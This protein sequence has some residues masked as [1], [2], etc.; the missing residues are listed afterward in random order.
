A[1]KSMGQHCEDMAREWKSGRRE[2][3]ELALASHK[4]TVAA[5]DAG[6]FDDLITPVDGVSRDAFP[7]RDTSMEKLSALKPAF[8]RAHG[9]LTAANNP[10]P[11]APPRPPP[12]PP[13]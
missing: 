1:G 2:Q 11:P 9:T 10:P 7:R 3:D 8:D 12:R 4:N 6:F 5:Q 13:P